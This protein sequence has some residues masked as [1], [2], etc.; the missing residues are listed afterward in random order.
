MGNFGYWSTLKQAR[1]TLLLQ[2]GLALIFTNLEASLIPTL[3]GSGLNQQF[4]TNSSVYSSLLAPAGISKINTDFFWSDPAFG[5]SDKENLGVWAQASIE[6]YENEYKSFSFS[7]DA[8]MLK[9]YFAIN[10][11]QMQTLMEKMYTYVKT[12]RSLLLENHYCVG[13]SMKDCT[14]RYLGVAQMADGWVTANTP[15]V[16]T[17]SPNDTICDDNVTCH[18]LYPE[19]FAFARNIFKADSQLYGRLNAEI[20]QTVKFPRESVLNWF[21][22]NNSI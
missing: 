2:Q 6:C 21:N 22:Y 11:I 14:G 9:N 16:S 3:L 18:G 20:L 8:I 1:P 13:V 19:P 5:M 7:R 17:I 12:L 10:D 4:L 15:P